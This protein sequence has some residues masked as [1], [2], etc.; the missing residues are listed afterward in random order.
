MKIINKSEFGAQG[1]KGDSER[2][3]YIFVYWRRVCVTKIA[4][5]ERGWIKLV[6]VKRRIC[7]NYILTH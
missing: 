2:D 4:G 5:D 1:V 7:C 3:P 6:G